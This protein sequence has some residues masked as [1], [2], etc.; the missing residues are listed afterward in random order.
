MKEFKWFWKKKVVLSCHW[1]GT[2]ETE[3]LIKQETKATI[4]CI[5]LPKMEEG[6]CISP[7]NHQKVESFCE[8]LLSKTHYYKI[9]MN[10]EDFR[11]IA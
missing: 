11:Y 5:P 6:Q 9:D 7:E 1:D 10:F 8:S 2:A 4:R 3:E